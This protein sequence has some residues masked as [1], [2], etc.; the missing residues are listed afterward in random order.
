MRTLKVLLLMPLCVRAWAA[1]TIPLN[2]S[3]VPNKG[4]DSTEVM[5]NPGVPKTG[6]PRNNGKAAVDPLS[7]APPPEL[8]YV[9]SVE[10]FGS[11]RINEKKLR[12]FLGKDLNTW[13][14]KGVRSDPS[15]LQMEQSFKKRIAEKWGFP[16]VEFSVVQYFEPGNRA[17]HITLDVVEPKDML[18]RMPFLPPPQ[19]RFN[20]PDGLLKAW[21]EYETTALG[22]VDKGELEPQ[23]TKCAAF[24]CPFGHKH[25]KLK[26]FEAQFVEGVKKNEKALVEILK[27]DA[28]FDNRASSAYLLAYLPDGNKVISYMVDR[29]RDPSDLVRNNVL[30]VLGDM[31]DGHPEFVIPLRPVAEAMNFPRVSDRSKSI[32][33]VSNLVTHSRDARDSVMKDDIPVVLRILESKQP[34]HRDLA[35]MILRKVSGKDIPPTDLRAWNSWW[36]KLA[37]ERSVAKK[38]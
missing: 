20:D 15:S 24:H 18:T 13:I 27:N 33:V 29:I 1:D 26:K 9:A 36:N 11:S 21:L 2:K 30:R 8:P 5:N 35:H 12:E 10:T 16:F 37:S 38:P 7:K 23:T 25:P 32:Y 3:T 6:L 31:A 22:L 14:E 28:A 19:G 4:S 17:I 34:D